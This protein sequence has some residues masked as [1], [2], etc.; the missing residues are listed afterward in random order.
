MLPNTAPHQ[1]HTCCPLLF[2][3][4]LLGPRGMETQPAPA[5]T[6]PRPALPSLALTLPFSAPLTSATL[7]VQPLFSTPLFGSS[8]LRNT[9][10]ASST[11]PMACLSTA[12]SNGSM[13]SPRNSGH[14]GCTAD[15]AS[16]TIMKR[17][18][19]GLDGGERTVTPGGAAIPPP[20][21]APPGAVGGVPT[22]P[23]GERPMPPACPM[24]CPAPP[25]PAGACTGALLGVPFMCAAVS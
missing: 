4:P 25:G 9:T 6:T 3:N 11:G 10:S 15:V 24:P 1:S 21:P 8:A 18:P 23:A 17:D 16:S 7:V 14:M 13:Y 12:R 5:P 2:H 20:P 22:V 19:A